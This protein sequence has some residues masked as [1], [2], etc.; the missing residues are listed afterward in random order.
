MQM[1]PSSGLLMML[2]EK[3]NISGPRIQHGSVGKS[4]NEKRRMG[5][6]MNKHWT[7]LDIPA[8]HW[9]PTDDLIM[10]IW[11]CWNIHQ[12]NKKYSPNDKQ[13]P[14]TQWQKPM[15]TNAGIKKI[16]QLWITLKLMI[17]ICQC[18]PWLNLETTWIYWKNR[19]KKSVVKSVFKGIV[20]NFF[21][22]GQNSYFE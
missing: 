22:F 15:L 8:V 18:C 9:C 11:K 6:D 10:Q 7:Y 13:A 1:V 19:W 5:C 20:H 12:M 14:T 4:G 21:I 16:A 3:L 2:I 17:L